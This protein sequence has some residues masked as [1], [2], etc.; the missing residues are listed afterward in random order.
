MRDMVLAANLI[1]WFESFAPHAYWDVNAWRIGF[2]SDTRTAAQIRVKR[3]DVTTR[4]EALAN[5]ALRIPQY[6]AT[7]AKQIGAD[8]WNEL[9]ANAQA[10]L[11]SFAYNYGSLTPTLCVKCE[12]GELS[13]IAEALAE[14]AV[15]NSGVNAV[16]RRTEA[17]F[18]ASVE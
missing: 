5:L 4:A 3:G 1:A 16:R 14:R 2:G 15:D 13:A 6:E 17:A 12:A 7:I 8:R 18:V 11:A 9:P 10:A